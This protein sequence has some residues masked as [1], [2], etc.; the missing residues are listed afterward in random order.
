MAVTTP[1]NVTHP[2]GRNRTQSPP[3]PTFAWLIKPLGTAAVPGETNYVGATI[4]RESG[5]SERR[6]G[7]LP[8][9]RIDATVVQVQQVEKS[10]ASPVQ[11]E[12]GRGIARRCGGASSPQFLAEIRIW[13]WIRAALRAVNYKR[14]SLPGKPSNGSASFSPLEH[15]VDSLGCFYRIKYTTYQK[16]KLSIFNIDINVLYLCASMG[17]KSTTWL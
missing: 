14:H 16:I 2:G 17:P 3:R 1:A 10:R 15:H 5:A 6:E 12:S 4:V 13:P 7:F 8:Y 9:L 11:V